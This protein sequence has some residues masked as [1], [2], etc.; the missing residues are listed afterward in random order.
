MTL[1]PTPL[2]DC[3]VIEPTPFQD[4]RGWFCRVFCKEAFQTVAPDLEW[5]QINH[6]FTR[7]RG[8]LRG[9]HFQRPPHAEAKLVRCVAGAVWDTVVD[10]RRESPTFLHAFAVE[11][12]AAN[13]KMLYIPPRFAHGFQ[14]LADDCELLYH[15]T[16][17]YTPQAEG[18]LRY[19]DPR[20]ALRWPL[21]PACLSARDLAHPLLDNTF[22]GL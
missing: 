6:S 2:A 16:H 11:L 10:L 3:C 20:L 4:E 1:T 13:R 17:P 15:H 18:G 14:T 19:D 7:A 12:S 21:P 8:A 9:L 22:E 5:V